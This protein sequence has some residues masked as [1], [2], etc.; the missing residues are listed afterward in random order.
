M[1]VHWTYTGWKSTVER[2][3]EIASKLDSPSKNLYTRPLKRENSGYPNLLG[4]PTTGSKSECPSP[5][6]GMTLTAIS[7]V[8]QGG[9]TTFTDVLNVK[10]IWLLSRSSNS[11]GTAFILIA[12]GV[13]PV[14]YLNDVWICEVLTL[15]RV[16]TH[17]QNNHVAHVQHLYS[18]FETLLHDDRHADVDIAL[19]CGTKVK[20]A[21]L[22]NAFCT[23]LIV[24][25]ALKEMFRFSDPFRQYLPLLLSEFTCTVW[26]IANDI[27]I[28][29][30]TL[31]FFWS[32]CEIF[33]LI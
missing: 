26:R 18:Y 25:V 29:N 3:N 16:K 20:Y 23:M 6:N 4:V 19:D 11:L 27:W 21:C 9:G 5:R 30:E 14:H 31:S 13:F 28:C 10:Y 15:P 8:G 2:A 24:W 33:L 7:N 32:L 22:N 12:G 17:Q 1:C